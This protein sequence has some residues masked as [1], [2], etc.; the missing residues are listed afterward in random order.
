MTTSMPKLHHLMALEGSSA[1][2]IRKSKKDIF[3]SVETLLILN[4]Y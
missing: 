4:Y 2:E 1:T 3:S